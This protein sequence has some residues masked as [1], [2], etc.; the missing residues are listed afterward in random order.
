MVEAGSNFE[1]VMDKVQTVSSAIAKEMSLLSEFAERLGSTTRYSATQVGELQVELS[2]LG[3][4]P[5]EINQMTEA[6]LNLATTTDS[7]LAE[8]ASVA[9]GVLRAFQYDTIM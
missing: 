1:V 7:K 9:G 8:S 4:K 3:F 2:K 5:D 6:T